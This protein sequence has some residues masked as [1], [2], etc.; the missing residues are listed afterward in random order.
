MKRSVIENKILKKILETNLIW[1][2]IIP[3]RC[4][5]SGVFEGGTSTLKK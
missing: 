5:V 1:I 3:H 4:V 2:I